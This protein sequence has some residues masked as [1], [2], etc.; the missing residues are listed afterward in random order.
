MAS[1]VTLKF[2]DVMLE[3]G[4]GATPTEVFAAPCGLETLGLTVNIETNTT[5]V[6]DCSAPDLE[7]W[8]LSDVV[9]KQMVITGEGIMDG[10]AQKTWR[11]WLLAGGEKNVRWHVDTTTVNG[12]GYWAAKAILTTYEE[13]GER[14][15]RW[16][17]N[18]GLTLQGKPTWTAAT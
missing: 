12:G 10:P 9:S 11:E 7:G 15:S 8:L 2:G 1:A 16:R 3:L 6:P 4:N 17:A 14:G 13:N 18:I 5:N